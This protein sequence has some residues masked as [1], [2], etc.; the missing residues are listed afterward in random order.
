MKYDAQQKKTFFNK[1][2]M[3]GSIQ[4]KKVDVFLTIKVRLNRVQYNPKARRNV[5]N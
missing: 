2:F 4:V 1:C 3:I 5:L